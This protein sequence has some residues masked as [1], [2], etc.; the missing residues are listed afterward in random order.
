[1]NGKIGPHR[2][3]EFILFERG[4]KHVAYFD[5]DSWPEDNSPAVELLRANTLKFRQPESESESESYIFYRSGYFA[6]AEELRDIILSGFT[7]HDDDFETKEYRIGEI[8]GYTKEDVSLYI[9]TFKARCP[10]RVAK[11]L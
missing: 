1:M 4:E 10:N 6:E 11:G 8:L 2:G 3:I 7:V 5:W 9:S